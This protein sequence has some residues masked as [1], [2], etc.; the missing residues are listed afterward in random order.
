MKLSI[1]SSQKNKDRIG[2]EYEQAFIRLIACTLLLV[3][4]AISYH[5]GAL[6]HFN[7]VAMYFASI[8]FCILFVIWTKHDSPL[9]HKR[10]IIAMLIEISTTTYALAYGGQATAP[11][12]VVYF[13]LIFGNGIRHGKNYLFLHT[14]LTIIGFLIVLKISPFWSEQKHISS[15]LLLAMI[16][17][18]LY[19][20]ALL[21]RLHNA[22]Q[23][24][25]NANNAKSLFLANMSHEIR[26]PLNGVIGM[27]DLLETTNL[28]KV[29]NDYV[30]TIQSSAKALL[31]LIDDILDISKI[32]TGKTEVKFNNFSLFSLLTKTIETMQPIAEKKGLNCRLHIAP[33]VNNLVSGDDK[34]VQQVL[35]NLLGNSIKFTQTGDID[36]NIS[37]KSSSDKQSRIRFEI[38]DTGIGIADDAQ[39]SIFDKFTQAN[40]NISSTYGGTGLGASIAKNLIEIMGG[41]IGVTSTLG[42]GSNFWFELDFRLVSD[43]EAYDLS[44][45]NILLVSTYGDNHSIL[46][47]YFDEQEISWEHAITASEA[48]AIIHDSGPQ[49]SY[50]FIFIDN[51]GIGN[52]IKTFTSNIKM[53][54]E[55]K[56]ANLILLENSD[57][58]L[59]ISSSW[60]F[61]SLQSPMNIKLLENI[62]HASIFETQNSQIKYNIV[63]NPDIQLRFVI[64]EDNITNQKVI[65]RYI[66]SA[67]HIADIYDNGE[68]VL[69]ALEE[70]EYDI[71]IL[72]LHMPIMD[73]PETIK[74][75]K[76]MTPSSKQIP[77]IVLTANVTKEA[78]IECRE[79][80][81]N[82]YLSKPIK[83]DKLFDVVYSLINVEDI[84]NKNVGRTP[85]LKLVHPMPN[86]TVDNIDVTTLDNLALLGDSKEFMHDLIRVFLTDSKKL[87]N[88][89]IIAHNNSNYHEL[90]D[91]AHALKGSAQSIGATEMGRIASEIYTHSLGTD[92]DSISV[93]TTT[94][95]HIHD[96]TSSAL[97]T[98]LENLV[99]T[100]L[101]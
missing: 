49:N 28:N 62:L 53:N 47:S 61:S 38:I 10:L 88:S 35:I 94:L 21:H 77:I 59:D 7:V 82:A 41:E 33:N 81:V 50:D 42:R 34:L 86:K 23:D 44:N 20:G 52:S 8:P 48:E 97:N 24:A 101:K 39:L 27:S 5:I 75:Y 92:Y 98:Y 36:I 90:A 15:G 19:I 83:R 2:S 29:Q 63:P 74:L 80:G 55:N 30:K 57:D 76:F 45:L 68:L 96:N 73:G 56:S 65:K 11:L 72:D 32:E 71:I 6:E 70:Y 9:I 67:G 1:K 89:I 91:Y 17:L 85:Q 26:T 99:I 16:V 84:K 58:S 95:M 87:V 3:Y 51:N 25:E 4:V 60:F 37:S 54:A 79:M 66:E 13:W 46:V 78:E 22:I 69:D 100:A 12:I 18:P 93:Q 64:G 43:N 40:D 14:I 31:S